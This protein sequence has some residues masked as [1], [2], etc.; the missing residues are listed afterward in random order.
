MHLIIV[1]FKGEMKDGA[2]VDYIFILT[3]III[4]N[5]N[6]CRVVGF[7]LRSIICWF[8][9]RIAANVLSAARLVFVFQMPATSNL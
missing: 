4:D 8:S 2:C 3:I 1:D 7:C 9:R 5:T 6:N